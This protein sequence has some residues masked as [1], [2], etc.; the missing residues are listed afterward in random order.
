[1]KKL[2]KMYYYTSKGEK[3]LNCYYTN[4]PKELVEK[5]NLQDKE[6]QI[7]LEN[8]KIIIEAK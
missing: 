3:K 7:R 2:H 5:A 1:M 6:I 8:N 4:L